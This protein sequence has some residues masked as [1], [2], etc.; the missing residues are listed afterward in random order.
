MSANFLPNISEVTPTAPFRFWCQK[1]LPLVYDDSLSYYELLCKVV[2][3]LN[4]TIQDV[5]TL[6][7]DVSDIAEAYTQLEAYVNDYFDNLDVQQEINN[8]LDEMAE[9]GTLTAL[10]EPYLEPRLTQQDSY[11]EQTRTI[12][13]GRMNQQDSYNEETRTLVQS[14]VGHPFMAASSSDMTDHS[15][16]YVFTGSTGG[17]YT[18]GHWYYWNGTAWTDGGTYNAE[19][20]NTDTS[21][22][23]SGTPADAEATGD[24]IQ[25]L[26]IA[27]AMMPRV[28]YSTNNNYLFQSDLTM[29]GKAIMTQT[30]EVV[31]IAGCVAGYCPVYMAG[32]YKIYQVSDDWSTN[33]FYVPAFD[34][35]KNFVK[36]INCTEIS[37]QIVSFDIT[38]N[39]LIAIAYLGITWF[40]HSGTGKCPML[41]YNSTYPVGNNY[42]NPKMKF[43]DDVYFEYR[44]YA[45]QD[46]D[47]LTTPGYFLLH[48]NDFSPQTH[49]TLPTGFA[50]NGSVGT[51]AVIEPSVANGFTTQLLIDGTDESNVYIRYVGALTTAWHRFAYLHDTWNLVSKNDV[52]SLN[53]NYID[54]D[55]ENWIDGIYNVTNGVISE[56]TDYDYCYFELRG[57]GTYTRLVDPGYGTGKGFAFCNE[58]KQ[59]MKYEAGTVDGQTCTYSVTGTDAAKYKYIV[60]TRSKTRLDLPKLYINATNKFT[61]YYKLSPNYGFKTHKLYKKT[62]VC[63][64]DSICSATPDN[65][66]ERG[67]YFGRMKVGYQLTGTNYAVGGGVITDGLVDSEQNPLHCLSTYIDTIHTNYPTLDYLVLEG[68]TNDADKLGG[69]N[70]STPPTN[71]GSWTENDFSGSYNRYTFCGAV[72]TLFYKALMYYPKAKIGFIIAMEMGTDSGAVNNRKRYFDEIVK[73]AKKWH[74]PVLNLWE[75]AGV[76][77]RLTCFYDPTMSSAENIAAEKFYYDVQHPT[78]YGYEKMQNMIESWVLGL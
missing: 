65:P 67:G 51:I 71:W 28:L 57:A 12:V 4:N 50:G 55:N 42:V 19:A 34:I 56:N 45:P 70:G 78:S 6:A 38:E 61:D 1:V 74:I 59:W 77:A 31:D 15:K 68:G 49:A 21:L 3:Y 7:Q 22:T 27:R 32:N 58:G 25:T 18:N 54:T 62:M 43:R 52:I 13:A 72:E 46:L 44:G 47:T 73:I 64:G 36:K 17:G 20:V 23:Q 75:N 60:I 29:T 39:D 69:W 26:N 53:G 9:S 5:N 30:G 2:N 76:D 37:N 16:I 11:N 24:A 8:K 63:D 10:I 66:M 35:N 40:T 14:M 41:I 48:G 33:R